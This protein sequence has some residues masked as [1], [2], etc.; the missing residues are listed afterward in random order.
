[1]ASKTRIDDVGS[2]NGDN[3]ARLIELI[4]NIDY[5]CIILVKYTLA[6]ESNSHETRL[7]LH[8]RYGFLMGGKFATWTHTCNLYGFA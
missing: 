4:M 2:G 7:Y 8:H 5:T 1:M 6:M 3:H